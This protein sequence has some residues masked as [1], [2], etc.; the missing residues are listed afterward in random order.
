MRYH[1]G[2]SEATRK[3]LVQHAARRF[4]AAGLNT[5]IGRLMQE[6]GLT[7]GGFYAHFPGKNSLIQAALQQAAEEIMERLFHAAT[8]DPTGAF[9]KMV[10]AY[11]DEKHCQNPET[12]CLLPALAT[13]IARQDPEVQEHFTVLLQQMLGLLQGVLHHLPAEQ[14]GQHALVVLSTLAGSVMLARAV[15]D[16]QLKTAFLDAARSSLLRP[17]RTPE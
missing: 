8:T 9:E 6:L 14:R 7:H 16:P 12:G 5:G 3:R 17:F 1:A 15:S 11:L 13:E 4:R 2:H 10:L